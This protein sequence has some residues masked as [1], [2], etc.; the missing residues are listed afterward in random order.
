MIQGKSQV[1]A[2]MVVRFTKG[3]Q[4]FSY[5]VRTESPTIDIIALLL[6]LGKTRAKSQ[7]RLVNVLDYLFEQSGNIS[8]NSE[9]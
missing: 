8:L 1:K 3:C 6:C 4:Q 5:E 9:V 2:E 7:E